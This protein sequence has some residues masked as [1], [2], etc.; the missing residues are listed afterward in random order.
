[1]MDHRKEGGNPMSIW[2]DGDVIA[3]PHEIVVPEGNAL[4]GM[5]LRI[6]IYDRPSGVRYLR[7]DG[8]DSVVLRLDSGVR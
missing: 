3:D 6:G 8:S 1:M 4:D 7:E 2:A 5:E